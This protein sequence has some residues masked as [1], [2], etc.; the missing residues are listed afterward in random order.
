MC[1]LVAYTPGFDNVTNM[2]TCKADFSVIAH[3]VTENDGCD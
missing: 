3:I 1:L 2:P